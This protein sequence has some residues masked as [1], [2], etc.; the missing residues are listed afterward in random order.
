M[1]RDY[2]KE[3][4][5]SVLSSTDNTLIQA[6]TGSGKTKILAYIAKSQ[7]NVLIIAHRNSLVSQLSHSFA[8]EK[9]QH[10]MLCS[11]STRR[12]A[13]TLHRRSLGKSFVIDHSTTIVCSV[14]TISSKMKRSALGVDVEKEWMIII[15][16]AHHVTENN[17]WGAV[18]AL[19]KNSRIVGATAT[20]CRL[21]DVSLKRGKGGVF[22][23]L[24]QAKSLKRDSVSKLIKRGFISSFRCFGVDSRIN[25]SALKIG[26][27]DYTKESLISETSK[28]VQEMAGDAVK[29]YARLAKNRQA[30]VFC[31][32]IDIADITAKS[33]R[34]SRV[35]AA[36]IHSK[37]SRTDI[38]RA[39][40]AFE[41]KRINV[42]CNVDMFGEGV[43]IPGIEALIMLRKTASFGLYRQWVGR[44][45]RVSSGKD[46][47]IIIDH[48][49]N[50]KQHGLPDLDVEW[51]LDRDPVHKK[52]NL[53][54]CKY[55]DFLVKAWA[56]Y[57]PNCGAVLR[58]ETGLSEREIKYVDVN[59]VEIHRS[60]AA[61]S[62]R[63]SEIASS[64]SYSEIRGLSLASSG[65]AG[66]IASRVALWFYEQIKDRVTIKQAEDFFRENN[67]IGF[68]SERF[69]L[70]DLKTKN[71]KKCWRVFNEA[72]RNK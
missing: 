66:E 52:S 47:A 55:C 18:C 1:L 30:V 48:A 17:K 2:Q 27:S 36:C 25:E 51:S 57:C 10:A 24:I 50:I 72:M 16:E 41:S 22:D 13:I 37:M 59:L 62:K 42:L 69:K 28:H 12:R 61:K 33:F 29:H 44:A 3:I 23:V 70:S 49:D 45:L 14:D 38:D 54:S 19:F 35:S 11:K 20:P 8:C 7:R 15:D 34:D 43:D 6:D 60:S 40:D 39:I 5:D 58:K 56:E 68:W 67:N 46:E 31:V 32:S 71:E 9:I 65:K 53:I 64:V 21:D 26:K 4:V 63:D